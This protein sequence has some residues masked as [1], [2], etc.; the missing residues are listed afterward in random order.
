M[1]RVKLKVFEN[2]KGHPQVLADFPSIESATNMLAAAHNV[3][4]MGKLLKVAFSRN[5]AHS[6]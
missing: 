6:N 2:A 4:F 5:T 3:D 1:D